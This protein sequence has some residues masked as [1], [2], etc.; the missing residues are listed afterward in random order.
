[1]LLLW[2]CV[3]MYTV[4]SAEVETLELALRDNITGKVL[5]S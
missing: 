2:L 1:M 4:Y 3:F 5:T